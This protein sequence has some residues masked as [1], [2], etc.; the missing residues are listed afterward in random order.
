MQFLTDSP[1]GSIGYAGSDPPGRLGR[2]LPVRLADTQLD[3]R[4]HEDGNSR[5]ARL[6]NE[7]P[8]N[9]LP[10]LLQQAGDQGIHERAVGAPNP[11][12]IEGH[13]LAEIDIGIDLAMAVCQGFG[14]I[15]K[16]RP[17]VLC[18]MRRVGSAHA[19]KVALPRPDCN[20]TKD[21]GGGFIHLVEGGES[22]SATR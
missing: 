7:L 14:T 22:I 6:E 8:E 12:E 17:A 16:D 18:K 21:S 2:D 13:L 11:G 3:G 15:G 4:L 19:S 5:L 10:V 9:L 1:A 20:I